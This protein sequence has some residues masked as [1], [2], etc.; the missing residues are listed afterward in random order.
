VDDIEINLDVAEGLLRP[1]KLT[2]D[3]AAGGLEAVRLV[4][5]NRY[6][7]VLMDHMMPGMDGM[8]AV[9]AIRSWEDKSASPSAPEARLPIIA[10]TANAISGMKEI[11][12]EKGFSDYL[13]KPIETT[14]LD[15]VMSRWIPPEKRIKTDAGIKRETFSGDTELWIPGVNTQKGIA[16]TGGTEAGYR[17][18]LVQFR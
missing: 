7:L 10:L 4:R 9:A 11:F 2:I 14:K 1:Y 16:M 13:S 3:R 12:L 6:D 5:E 8:E 18:V 17:K 15:E